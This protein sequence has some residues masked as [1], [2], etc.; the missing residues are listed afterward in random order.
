MGVVAVAVAIV[1]VVGVTSVITICGWMV[2]NKKKRKEGELRLVPPYLAMKMRLEEL[3]KKTCQSVLGYI[4]ICT[5][6][7]GFFAQERIKCLGL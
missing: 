3:Y 4:F 7:C 2:I 5:K 6:K 1:A